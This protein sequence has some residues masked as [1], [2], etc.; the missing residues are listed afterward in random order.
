[1]VSVSG[2]EVY[3]LT[4]LAISVQIK[5]GATDLCHLT[6]EPV[7]PLSVNNALLAP[8]QISDPPVTVPPT[9]GGFTETTT[10][11]ETGRQLF[12]SVTFNV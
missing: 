8:L 4:L 3:V 9:E 6:T 7:C 5:N 2:P 10:S 11:F 12:A 1:V